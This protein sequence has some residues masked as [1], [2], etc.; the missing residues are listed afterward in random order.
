MEIIYDMLTKGAL[1]N[2]PDRI[3]VH[4]MGEV[5]NNKGMKYG[6]RDWLKFLGLSAH[7]LVRPD[8]TLIRCRTD[9]EGAYHAR[10]YNTNSLGIEFLVAGTHDYTSFLKAIKTDWVSDAQ[11]EEGAAKIK[12]WM[13][14]FHIPLDRIDRHSTLSPGRKVDPGEGFD[15][16]RFTGLLT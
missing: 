9:F 6:A 2:S 8:G 7:I 10:G 3:V 5:I 11:Y 13:D 16:E 12:E 14:K 1:D 15:F 4:A